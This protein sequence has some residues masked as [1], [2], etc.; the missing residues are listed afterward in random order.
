MRKGDVVRFRLG[1]IF[2]PGSLLFG[3]VDGVVI[4]A[5]TSQP[6]PSAMVSL[7]QP[8]ASGMQTLASVKSDA[9]GKFKIDKDVPPGPALVQ[10]LYQGATY[11]VVL[12]PGP[13]TTGL[14]LEVYDSTSKPG[15]A[16]VAQQ[17]VLI[18]PGTAALQITETFLV[19]NEHQA[20]VSGSRARLHPVLR[21]RGWREQ[22]AGYG[23]RAGRHAHSSVRRK[24]QVKPEFTR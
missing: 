11:N 24:R 20:H 18:E 1:L 6:Q 23:Q 17:M 7:V 4:N 14:R 13:P 12:T 2:L 21:A 10:A 9:E 22:R 5:T 19:Q 15:T 8:S 3:A 16:K